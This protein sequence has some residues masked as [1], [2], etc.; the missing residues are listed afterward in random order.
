MNMELMQ[1]C[2]KGL[3]SKPIKKP[4]AAEVFSEY[5]KNPFSESSVFLPD[6]GGGGRG[7]R[8]MV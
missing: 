3:T 6:A 1:F 8:I 5:W 2:Q 7:P 4:M